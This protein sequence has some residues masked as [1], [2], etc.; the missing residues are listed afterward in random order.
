MQVNPDVCFSSFVHQELRVHFKIDGIEQIVFDYFANAF[1]VTS[2]SLE[3]LTRDKKQKVRD[4]FEAQLTYPGFIAK[5]II[6]AWQIQHSKGTI[7]YIGIP[8]EFFRFGGPDFMNVLED[9]TK[10]RGWSVQI[11][12]QKHAQFEFDLDPLRKKAKKC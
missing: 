5:Q 9:V 6:D 12:G 2:F 7:F 1:C 10:E 8:D 4:W 11:C 3:L